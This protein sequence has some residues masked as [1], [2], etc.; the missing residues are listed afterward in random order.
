MG[1][2]GKSAYWPQSLEGDP[3]MRDQV[4]GRRLRFQLITQPTDALALLKHQ[5][6]GVM[7]REGRIP[8][9]DTV[10][11]EGIVGG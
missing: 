6:L 5:L 1:R 3:S 10:F 8:M 2:A 9:V 11:D 7:F 4:F